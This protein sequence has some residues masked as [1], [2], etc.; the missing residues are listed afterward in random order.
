MDCE[1][2]HLCL[3][4]CERLEFKKTHSH[5]T[6][7]VNGEEQHECWKPFRVT[8]FGTGAVEIRRQRWYALTFF[9]VVGG[10]KWFEEIVGEG[11]WT[12]CCRPPCRRRVRECLCLCS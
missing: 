6:V 11:G 7:M 3:A 9:N 5:G 8:N 1:L 12:T 10:A 4:G 2:R